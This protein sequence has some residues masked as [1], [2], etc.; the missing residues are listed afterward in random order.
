MS[1]TPTANNSSKSPASSPSSRHVEHDSQ[2][3]LQTH[4]DP[5]TAQTD[6][7]DPTLDPT[8][9][10]I[11]PQG[12][13]HQSRPEQDVSTRP[14]IKRQRRNQQT[15]MTTE[16]A[17]PT[18][19][20]SSQSGMAD[21]ETEAE[22]NPQSEVSTPAAAPP[23][24]K[25]TRTLTTPHQSAVLHAL[26]AKSRFPTTAMREEVGRQ[27]GLS[28]RK[29]Q[30]WFQN[31]RQKARRPQSDSAPLTRPPQFGPFPPISSSAPSSSSFRSPAEGAAVSETQAEQGP[32][33][34]R[35]TVPESGASLDSNPVLSGPGMPGWR[36]AYQRRPASAEVREPSSHAA[37]SPESAA[38][39]PSFSRPPAEGNSRGDSREA[40]SRSMRPPVSPPDDT[41][42]HVS[43]LLPPINIRALEPRSSADPYVSATS[44]FPPLQ[45]RASVNVVQRHAAEQRSSASPSIPP[46][47]ALQP[48]PQWDPQAFTPYTRP[49]FTSWS[50]T[51]SSRSCVFQSTP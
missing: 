35:S 21:N 12:S 22:R 41:S 51:G 44:P 10:P 47:F 40:I 18:S 2:H 34:S 19:D 11:T 26:L 24:K 9:T 37:A 50:T 29:V 4:S 17:S 45:P 23:K 14:P 16:R 1:T 5:R 15:N 42:P 7:P 6:S 43:R 48:Q 28:A 36:S 49:E 27:I 33:S 32:S 20:S 46:P 31:Q 39:G 30:I 38:G 25:R 3:R 13:S 8:S